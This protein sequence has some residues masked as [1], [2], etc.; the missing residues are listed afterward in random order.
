MSVSGTVLANVG[1]V[2]TSRY[3]WYSFIVLLYT[4]VMHNTQSDKQATS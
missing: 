3:N 2:L 4:F 1:F